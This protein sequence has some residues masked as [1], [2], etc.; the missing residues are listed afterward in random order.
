MEG[1]ALIIIGHAE[2]ARSSD[3]V[4]S[5]KSRQKQTAVSV[6]AVWFKI[7]TVICDWRKI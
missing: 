7:R 2:K 5:R 1:G 4:A 3:H 6:G